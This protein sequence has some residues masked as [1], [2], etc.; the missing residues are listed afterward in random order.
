ME[1][2]SGTT[3]IDSTTGS[4]H[5][6]E[7]HA[8]VGI[9]GGATGL[10]WVDLLANGD[11]QIKDGTGDDGVNSKI[12]SPATDFAVHANMAL[13]SGQAGLIAVISKSGAVTANGRALQTDDTAGGSDGGSITV[14]AHLGVN[15]DDAQILSRGDFVQTGGFR[16]RRSHHGSVLYPRPEAGRRRLPMTYRLAMLGQRSGDQGQR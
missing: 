5:H 16:L 2:W 15:L 3:T 11:I 1:I 9:S 10:G 8:D 6:G 13:G 4:G 7:V 12:P 14:L